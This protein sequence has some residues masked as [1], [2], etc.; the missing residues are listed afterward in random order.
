VT[1]I[2]P[3][4]AITPSDG[5]AS[6]LHRGEPY[7]A[8]FVIWVAPNA[9]KATLSLQAIGVTLSSC[10]SEHV[11]AGSTS[12]IMCLARGRTNTNASFDVVV[13]TSDL[14]TYSRTFVHALTG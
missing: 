3:G 9:G 8:E 4:T 14:G 5:L 13:R 10:T 11:R 1:A 2:V 6:V 12:R 7:R